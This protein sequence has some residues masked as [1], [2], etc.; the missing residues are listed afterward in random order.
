MVKKLLKRLMSNYLDKLFFMNGFI[1]YMN[2]R[3]IES[4]NINDYE[5]SCFSQ[6]G[7]DGII[8]RI[9]QITRI[10]SKTFIEFGV[11]NFTESNCR[12]LMKKDNWKGL[13]ID[14]S[15][16]NIND[17]KQ[18]ELYWRHS[19]LAK[20]AFITRENVE[21][22]IYVDE[23]GDNV[24]ILSIDIDGN[25][26]HIL[27]SIRKIK[28]SII[29]CEYNSLFGPTR[30]IT[31]P[32]DPDFNRNNGSNVF[33]GASISALTVLANKKGYS[34]IGSNSAGNNLFFVRNDLITKQHKILT[35][36]EAYKKSSF[37]E[38][39]DSGGRLNYH[40]FDEIVS[41]LKGRIVYNVFTE[42]N[43]VF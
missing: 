28:A 10:E 11:E 24:G 1:M 35:P 29:I 40:F 13:V 9:I 6:W 25:D 41:S 23:I 26:Y 18:S 37:R 7:E 15:E 20:K 43:E 19:L 8:Q 39:R 2:N 30:T 36:L 17:I 21:E 27:E 3:Q 5:F 33:Y 34:L 4:D 16:T 22:L 14:S 38:L 32:Y 42:K 12:F 31:I